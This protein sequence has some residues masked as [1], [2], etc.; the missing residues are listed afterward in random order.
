M[1]GNRK[2]KTFYWTNVAMMFLVLGA[3]MSGVSLT[4]DNIITL[5]A[6]FTANGIAFVGGNVGE[7]F[8][9]AKKN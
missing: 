1:T 6:L 4:G 5:S 3:F 9:N 8:A 2:L 7:H